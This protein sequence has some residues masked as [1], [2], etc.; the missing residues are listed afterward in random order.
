M[1][2]SIMI[3]WIRPLEV[4]GKQLSLENGNTYDA[5]L[6]WSIIKQNERADVKGDLDFKN[7][8]KWLIVLANNL[9]L[10]MSCSLFSIALV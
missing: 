7:P 5:Y 2:Q 4:D 1:P 6:Q 3:K 8:K 9:G 10:K